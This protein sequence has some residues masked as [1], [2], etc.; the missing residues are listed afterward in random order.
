MDTQIRTF[1]NLVCSSWSR[2]LLNG[3]SLAL[4]IKLQGTIHP[5]QALSGINRNFNMT[6]A[7]TISKCP[8]TRGYQP[9]LPTNKFRWGTHTPFPKEIPGRSW[10]LS[11]TKGFGRIANLSKYLN[12]C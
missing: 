9:C 7:I 4:T 12:I 5:P 10:K 8:R 1:K 11:P 2:Q 6:M 3:T